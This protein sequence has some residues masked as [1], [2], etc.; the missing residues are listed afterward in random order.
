M[1]ERQRLAF[2]TGTSSGIGLS[3]ARRLLKDQW[4]VCGL[5]RR[6]APINDEGYSH[7]Q[8]DLADLE[9]LP[10]HVQEN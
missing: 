9:N 1:K 6:P 5:S 3:L 4:Q 2:V 8:I 10:N 7:L